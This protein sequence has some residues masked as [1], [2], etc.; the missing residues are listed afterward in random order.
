MVPSSLIFL[1]TALAGLPIEDDRWLPLQIDG[2]PITD[3]ADD[4]FPIVALDLVGDEATP[5]GFWSIDEDE[6]FFRIR[7]TGSP[8]TLSLIHI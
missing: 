8:L 5:L 2:A 3:D 1:S 4:T 6:V 7:L